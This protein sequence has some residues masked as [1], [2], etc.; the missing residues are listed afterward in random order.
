MV[1]RAG[2]KARCMPMIRVEVGMPIVVGHAGVRVLP[3]ERSREVSMFGFMSSTV[4][5]EKPKS[6]SVQGVVD[7]IRTTRADGKKVLARR[8]PGD[9][10]YRLGRP[11]RPVDPR[12]LDPGPLRR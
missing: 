1:D 5:S 10:S 7:A 6:V 8:R 3:I 12:G 9:R 11:C 2:G 4:S